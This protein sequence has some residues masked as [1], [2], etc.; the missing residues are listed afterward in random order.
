MHRLATKIARATCNRAYNFIPEISRLI[1]FTRY[2]SISSKS[3]NEEW[4][5]DNNAQY[6][7]GYRN[8]D[9]PTILSPDKVNFAT[10]RT[11][12][13]ATIYLII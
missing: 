9:S 12:E 3:S 4:S 2:T 11:W 7:I 1:A 6:F 10:A 8:R 13:S 5:L